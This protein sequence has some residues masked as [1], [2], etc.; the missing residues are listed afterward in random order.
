MKPAM[1]IERLLA[2]L[3]GAAI[4]G[5]WIPSA[6]ADGSAPARH[7]RG[8]MP[9]T[10]TLRTLSSEYAP[11]VFDHAAHLGE[12]EGCGQC[13]HRHDPGTAAGCEGCH[14]LDPPGSGTAV[15]AARVRPCGQ[16]HPA[17]PS[18]TDLSR[19]ALKAAYHRVCFRCHREVGSVGEDPK[20][21]TEMCHA[22]IPI[23][24]AF[25]EKTRESSPGTGSR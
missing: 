13:H 10:I 6:G 25:H 3:L 11:V 1:R 16:C 15:R 24:E 14:S 8:R 18:R 17:A 12:A 2:I 9:G 4:C 5:A 22:R 21:C 20:G 23:Q 7:P 19:P